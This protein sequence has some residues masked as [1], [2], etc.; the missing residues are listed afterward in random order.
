MSQ[1][2]GVDW[3]ALAVAQSSGGHALV[4]DLAAQL[5]L[6]DTAEGR[7]AACRCEFVHPF[8]GGAP[9]DWGK[10]S[11]LE[12][13]RALFLKAKDDL[14]EESR[15]ERKSDARAWMQS[16]K[17]RIT[18]ARKSLVAQHHASSVDAKKNQQA[19][20]EAHATTQWSAALE[21]AALPE[22]ARLTTRQKEMKRLMEKARGV[23]LSDDA[24]ASVRSA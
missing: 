19:P 22:A 13:H 18:E 16:C 10:S 9:A 1:Q 8:C 17:R 23:T 4:A 14:E 6:P 11:Y 7:N 3:M 20:P 15:E 2:G 24:P 12:E 21:L 5:D